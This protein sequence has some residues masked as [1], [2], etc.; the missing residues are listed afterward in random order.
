MRANQARN[1]SPNLDVGFKAPY[2][3]G[4]VPY[5]TGKLKKYYETD[6]R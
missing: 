3:I 5:F 2:R 4:R 6:L 1:Q